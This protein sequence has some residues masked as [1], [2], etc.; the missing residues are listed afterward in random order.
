MKE[1]KSYTVSGVKLSIVDT[2]V[3]A[4]SEE[5]AIAA[6]KRLKQFIYNDTYADLRGAWSSG[7]VQDEECIPLGLQVD[8]E[9]E[10]DGDIDILRYLRTMFIRQ[11]SWVCGVFTVAGRDIPV[12]ARTRSEVTTKRFAEANGIN[13]IQNVHF[14]LM[15]EYDTWYAYVPDMPEL[16]TLW[17]KGVL[18]IKEGK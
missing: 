6:A 10:A 11:Y 14:S 13:T 5:D 18:T 1:L 9:I 15:T 3:L 12:Y 2:E 8:D 16:S 17:D 4:Y 7:V